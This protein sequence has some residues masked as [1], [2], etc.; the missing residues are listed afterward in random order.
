MKTPINYEVVLSEDA[1]RDIIDFKTYIFKN[2]QYKEYAENFSKKIKTAIK[3]LTL[4][5]QGYEKTEFVIEGQDIYYKPYST[6]LIFFIIEG[7]KVVIARVLKDGMHWQ[8]IMK[9]A[10]KISK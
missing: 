2:F 6:Y 7:E 1:T 9:R 5:A 3:K 10:V 4:F 8:S